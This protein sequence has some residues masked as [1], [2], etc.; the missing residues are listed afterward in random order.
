MYLGNGAPSFAAISPNLLFRNHDGERFV[1]VTTA[2]GTGHLQKGHG[3]AIGDIDGDGDEDIFANMGGF[4]AADAYAK[5]LFRNP[6]HHRH[7]LSMRL[8]GVET[9][10]P[11]IGAR[12][13]VHV[14][15]A[16]GTDR[17]ISRVVSSGG[18]F[19]GSPLT[20]HV[21]L[22]DAMAVSRVEIYWPVSRLTQV[23]EHPA[24]D[25]TTVVT[26]P[27]QAPVTH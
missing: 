1:D 24:I 12:V 10:R 13:A 11:A 8:V 18:S 9:N 22:G 3:I 19:G 14:P 2:S 25:R 17:L 7:W 5:V 4:V 6:G 16:N 15:L 20:V 23:I 27:V 26:E 21:G